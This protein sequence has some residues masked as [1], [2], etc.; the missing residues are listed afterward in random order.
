MEWFFERWIQGTGIP[1]Y[2][3]EFTIHKSDNGTGYSIRGKLFQ[4]NVPQ[5]FIARV[6][7]YASIPGARPVLLGTVVAAGP[8]TQ[9]RFTSS[10]SPRKLLIDPQMTLLC[11]TQ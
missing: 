3:A 8:E 11:T 2:R 4:E 10:T 9:F 1:H 6:P 7:L 5:S